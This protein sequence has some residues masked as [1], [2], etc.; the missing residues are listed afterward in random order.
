MMRECVCANVDAEIAQD[1]SDGAMSNGFMQPSA[2]AQPGEPDGLP[3]QVGRA[4]EGHSI[5][6]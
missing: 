2:H 4:R 6:S 1:R 3:L 5:V